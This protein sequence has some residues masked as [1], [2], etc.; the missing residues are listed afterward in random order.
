VPS[1]EYRDHRVRQGDCITS[2]AA[3]YGHFWDVVWNDPANAELKELRQ[4]PNLLHEGDIVRVPALRL[5]TFS[6]ST[7]ATHRF[8]RK[9]IPATLK[10]RFT[11]FDEPRKD[12]P[13]K[14]LVDGALVQE[15][16]LD[17]DGQLEARI[18]P[19]AKKAQVLLGDPP[20]EHQFLLGHLPPVTEI[21]GVHARLR[22]LC[23]SVGAKADQLTEELREALLRFQRDQEIEETGEPDEATQQ[24]LV[25]VHGC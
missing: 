18:E 10:L 22:N 20:E 4:H 23:Y 21:A 12:L 19:G 8:R 24:K 16:T 15:G 13:Y 3:A 1:G 11:D 5:R 6:L 9:G 7:G 14:L 17:G 25:E 2:I